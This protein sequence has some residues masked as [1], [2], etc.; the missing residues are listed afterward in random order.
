MYGDFLLV[1]LPRSC[2]LVKSWGCEPAEGLVGLDLGVHSALIRNLLGGPGGLAQGRS[3]R[4]LIVALATVWVHQYDV[5]FVARPSPAATRGA[6][7]DG[8]VLHE[9]AIAGSV[10]SMVLSKRTEGR[11]VGVVLSRV[12][13]SP[14][15]VPDALETIDE[16]QARGTSRRSAAA[17][18]H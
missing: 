7:R 13:Q 9:L 16:Q 15:V 5:Q 11:V 10:V 18:P 12:G 3:S 4:T 1:A 6:E 8:A 14:G 17:P 2:C